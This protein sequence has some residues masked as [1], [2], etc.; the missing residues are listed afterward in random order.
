MTKKVA[1]ADVITLS[2][3]E[4]AKC[5]PYGKNDRPCTVVSYGQRENWASRKAAIKFF[6][7]A[8]RVCEGCES[9]RY[10]NIVWDLEDG[11]DEASDKGGMY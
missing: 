6:S 11:L 2:S 3:A 1:L 10:L 8:A 9:R 7:F 5:G 4:A